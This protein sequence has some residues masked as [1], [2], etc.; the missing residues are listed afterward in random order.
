MQNA[1]TALHER[2]SLPNTYFQNSFMMKLFFS[3]SHKNISWM[4]LKKSSLL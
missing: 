2:F 4:K 1:S 3:F